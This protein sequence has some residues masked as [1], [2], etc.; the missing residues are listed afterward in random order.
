MRRIRYSVAMSLDGYIAGPNDEID[1][2]IMDP[3]ID[4]GELMS[5][6]DT[7]LMGRL[8]FEAASAQPGG[9]AMPGMK[10]IVVSSTLRQEDHPDVTIIGGALEEAVSRLRAE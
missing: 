4:F 10:A 9:G 6:F 2:I 8:T 3:D 7:V 5:R 1:W